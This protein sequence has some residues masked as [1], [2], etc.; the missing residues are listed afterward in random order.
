MQARAGARK[1]AQQRAQRGGARSG[2]A[3][4]ARRYR[5]ADATASRRASKAGAQGLGAAGTAHVRRKSPFAANDQWMRLQQTY[6][7]LHIN[8]RGRKMSGYIYK[9]PRVIRNECARPTMAIFPVTPKNTG[10]SPPC[11]LLIPSS[12]FHRLVSG[13]R[14]EG[15]RRGYRLGRG[16]VV[17]CVL[18]LLIFM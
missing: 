18:L 10:L 7:T 5:S 11:P 15:Q 3:G 17:L 12:T 2:W 13:W 4:Q 1:S 16:V 8:G 9:A 6:F 14:V